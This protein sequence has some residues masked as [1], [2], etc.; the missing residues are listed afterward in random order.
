MST[1]LR[2]DD[3]YITPEQ[4]L[5][6][7]R[8]SDVKHEYIAGR[9]FAMA[10]A[11]RRH[12]AIGVNILRELSN[13]LRGK[14]CQ[15]FGSDM[16]LRIR[17]NS[18]SFYYYPDVT[19][20]CSGSEENEVDEPAVIF[21]VLSHATERVDNGEKL[22]HYRSIQSL[23]VYVQVD[24]ISAAVTVYRRMG[25]DWGIQFLGKMDAVLDLPE[26]ECRLPL[27]AIYERVFTELP[28]DPNS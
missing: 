26:I 3:Y 10:G 23:Q 16:R 5:A 17:T 21:E 24:Q 18:A 13:Q 27:A 25:P 4:Y 2:Q 14:K 15:P 8:L 19:V 20:D 9:V 22:Y 11:S 1:A 6:A 12:N 7:E 28:I